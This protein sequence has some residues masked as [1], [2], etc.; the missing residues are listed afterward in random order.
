V[1]RETIVY[2]RRHLVFEPWNTPSTL[3]ISNPPPQAIAALEPELE[4]A[5]APEKRARP[6]RR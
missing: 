5:P 4:P 2:L 6:A 3:A 1:L